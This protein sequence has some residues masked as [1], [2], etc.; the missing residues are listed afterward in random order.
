M[1]FPPINPK[2]YVELKSNVSKLFDTGRDNILRL[3]KDDNSLGVYN[4]DYKETTI[5]WILIL[6]DSV[7]EVHK[8]EGLRNFPLKSL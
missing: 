5:D 2:R 8:I 7:L 3:K 6:N 1:D 4:G